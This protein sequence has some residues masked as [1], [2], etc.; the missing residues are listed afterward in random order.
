MKL[1]ATINTI[2]VWAVWAK[3]WRIKSKSTHITLTLGNQIYPAVQMDNV[4]LPQKNE[5]K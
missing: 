5:V 1:I 4:A 2:D 3:K